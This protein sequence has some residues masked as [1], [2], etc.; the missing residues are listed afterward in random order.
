MTDEQTL[1]SAEGRCIVL[2]DVPHDVLAASMKAASAEAAATAHDWCV[3]EAPDDR[4]EVEKLRERGDTYLRALRI[5]GREV[6]VW[7]AKAGQ[8]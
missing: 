8:P 2:A 4:P 7:R 5:L 6:R 3:A 1:P